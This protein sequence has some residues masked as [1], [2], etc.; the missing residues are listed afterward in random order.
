ML[1]ALVREQ[2]PEVAADSGGCHGDC[3][4][5]QEAR[6][7]RNDDARREDTEEGKSKSWHVLNR[8]T[9]PGGPR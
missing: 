3:R 5:G 6:H 2:E 7:L 8:T 4:V 1:F 9:Y